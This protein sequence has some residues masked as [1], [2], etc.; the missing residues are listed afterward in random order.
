MS[1]HMKITPLIIICCL[2]LISGP[3]LSGSDEAGTGDQSPAA[4][5]QQKEDG[6]LSYVRKYLAPA[7]D[8]VTGQVRSIGIWMLK[9]LAV[10]PAS[11]TPRV[12]IDLVPAVIKEPTVI[13]KEEKVEAEEPKKAIRKEDEKVEAETPEHQSVS[14]APTDEKTEVKVVERDPARTLK[15]FFPGARKPSPPVEMAQIVRPKSPATNVVTSQP[16]PAVLVDK[17]KKQADPTL[18]SV[19]NAQM[20][21]KASVDTSLMLGAFVAMGESLGEQADKCI[22]KQNGYV[23][24]CIRDVVWPQP[25]QQ[26]FETS[27]IMYRGTKAI[28]RYDNKELTHAHA[29][30]FKSGLKAVVSYLEARY[31]PPLETFN[32]IVVPFEG[33][34]MDNPTYIWRKNESAAGETQA[35]TLEIRAIDDSR[36]GFPDMEHGLIR[37][38]GEGSQPIFPRVSP[39]EMMLVKH[40]VN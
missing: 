27:A 10:P 26:L 40:A 20:I 38:Y 37:L 18:K 22:K 5:Q 21:V 14:V 24:F 35:V 19:E 39:R 8:S 31:G 17:P 7:K 9:K 30:F 4:V 29:L 23:H 6:A 13:K 25:V 33:R 15:V 28:V 16:A 1:G 11:R 36:G 3:A 34:P 32:R 2:F 12:V